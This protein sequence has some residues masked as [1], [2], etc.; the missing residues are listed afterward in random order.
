METPHRRTLL[1]VRSIHTAAFAVVA[2]SVLTVLGDGIRAR[3]VRR[4]GVAL[5]VALGECVVFAGNGFVCPLTELAERYGAERGSVTDIF[6][7]GWLARNLAWV[8]GSILLIGIALNGRALAR[9]RS[10]LVWR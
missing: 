8:S 9:K 7:P 4:T 10:L 5:A 3:P 1:F 6:L 2:G